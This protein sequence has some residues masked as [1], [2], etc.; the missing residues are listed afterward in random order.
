MK[1]PLAAAARHVE[2]LTRATTWN[3]SINAEPRKA[4]TVPSNA[5]PISPPVLAI[6]LF[7]PDA[8]PVCAESTDPKTAVVSGATAKANPMDVMARLGKT[9]AH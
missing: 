2:A 4:S 5:V 3:A 1:I 8:E 7:R 6:A 9:A